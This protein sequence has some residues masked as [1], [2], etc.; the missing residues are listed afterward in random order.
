MDARKL[1]PVGRAIALFLGGFTLLNAIGGICNPHFD[2][3]IWWIDLRAIPNDASFTFLV[4]VGIL[5]VWFAIRPRLST[6]RWRLT[7]GAVAIITLI[8]AI[9]SAMFY[10]YFAR[11]QFNS[12]FPIPFSL[13]LIIAAAIVARST[14][15]AQSHKMQ[16]P[17]SRFHTTYF[18]ATF[19]FCMVLFPIAQMYCFGETDYRRPADAIVVHPP[20]LWPIA[21]ARRAIF[22]PKAMHRD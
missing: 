12:G 19:L 5:L 17:R 18:T 13:L 9:N 10:V 21:C 3:N 2:A 4:V 15:V 7:L 16:P 8:A 1:L 20:R 6:W 14:F 22:T 11:G